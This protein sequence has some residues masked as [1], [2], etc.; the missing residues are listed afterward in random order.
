MNFSYTNTAILY[1][2]STRPGIGSTDLSILKISIQYICIIC[3][4][5]LQIA[6]S[7]AKVF[8][9]LRIVSLSSYLLSKMNTPNLLSVNDLFKKNI[10]TI[11][12]A[13]IPGRGRYFDEEAR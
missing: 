10:S 8:C 13:D 11:T 2:R 6:K 1:T 12:A 4:Y 5:W 3:G 7:V 9:C